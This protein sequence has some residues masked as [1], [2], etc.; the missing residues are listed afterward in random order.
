MPEW[1]LLVGLLAGLLLGEAGG[2]SSDRCSSTPNRFWPRSTR[3]RRPWCSC[4]I[5]SIGST[6]AKRL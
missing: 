1:Y 2:L 5:W 3:P 4:S 6:G